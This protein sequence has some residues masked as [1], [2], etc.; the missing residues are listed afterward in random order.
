MKKNFKFILLGII[1]IAL[2]V[3]FVMLFKEND[4]T[5]Y[6][7]KSAFLAGVKEIYKTAKTQYTSNI[8]YFANING[9]SC[10]SD[11]STNLDYEGLNYYY[12]FDDNG[13]IKGTINQTFFVPYNDKYIFELEKDN[14]SIN[15]LGSALYSEVKNNPYIR[16]YDSNFK[17][18]CEGKING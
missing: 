3:I 1:I 12:S 16:D 11:I 15:D 2:I 14:I 13:N 17:I 8:K 10:N 4:K 9:K 18:S 7:D 6:Q 5:K